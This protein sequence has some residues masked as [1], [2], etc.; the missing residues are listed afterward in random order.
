MPIPQFTMPSADADDGELRQN[1]VQKTYTF[2]EY[3]VKGEEGGFRALSGL[4][5]P[6]LDQAW[7]EVA[8]SFSALEKSVTHIDSLKVSRHGIGGAQLRFKLGNVARWSQRLTE[9]GSPERDF[10]NNWRL[11]DRWRDYIEYLLESINNLLTS[12]LE[13]LGFGTDV[14]EMK[15]AIKDAINWLFDE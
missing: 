12:I 1:F 9:L 11:P 7:N 3:L 8:G 15:D 5:D 6:F 14:Q 13:A 10:L 4:D 2:L